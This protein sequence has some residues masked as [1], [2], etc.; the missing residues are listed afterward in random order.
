M[1][2]L[3]D[4]VKL[5]P[6]K[7]YDR[8]VFE[9]GPGRD[10]ELLTRPLEPLSE[11]ERRGWDQVSDVDLEILRHKF[12]SIVEEARDVY[13]NLSISEGII[14][15]DMNASIFTAQG[16]P[17]V[18][19][20]G[21]YFHALL[22]YAQVKYIL[23]YYR[24]DPTVGLKDGDIYFF[25][26][27][28]GG[29]V[30]T[31]DMFVTMPVFYKGQLIAW[32]EVGGHQG[33]T[34]SISPGGFSPKAKTRWEEGLHAHALRIGENDEIR[35]DILDF[36]CNS[37]RNP[38]VFASDL[39]AR[40]ATCVRIRERLLRE[41]ERR[42][43]EVVAA[44][45]RKILHVTAQQAR[46]RLRQL[47]DG[48][49]RNI[50]F[51]DTVGGDEGLL[52]IPT[53]VIKEDDRMTV[54]VQGVS[55]EHGMGPIHGTWHLTRAALGVYLFSYMF[56]GLPPNA[57]LLDP[58]EVL[59]EGPSFANST[60]E[61]AHGEGTLP[62][63]CV[64]QN[65]HVIGSKMLFDSP[66]REAVCAPHSR[67]VLVYIYAGQNRYGYTAANFT[68]TANAGGQGA[69]FDLDGEHALGFFW[70]PFTD[71]GEVEDTDS[72]LP[73]LVL[74][75]TIGKNYHGFG[76]FRGGS[77]LIEIAAAWG[78]R[79]CLMT[80]WGCCDKVSHN[81]GIFGGYW[82][83]PNPR[84]VITKTNLKQLLAEK[85]DVDLADM[86]EIL[87]KQ[88]IQGNYRF[89]PSSG[90][91][92]R[93]EEGDVFIWNIGAGGGYGDVLERDPELVMEDVRAGYITPDIAERIYKV[94]FDP[95]T[96]R[97]DHEATHR[98]RQA[99]REDR[100]RRGKPFHEFIDQ[101]LRQRPKPEILKYYGHWPEPNLEHYDKPFWGLY[102]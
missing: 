30:H 26:D 13:M 66:Y 59:V 50:L 77:P 62:A 76:K 71:S 27:E 4:Q 53:T 7:I 52:R 102:E 55:P 20:T 3:R 34:G 10:P 21:I 17:A 48:I 86:L 40:V 29:G 57:G 41:V 74:A 8:D 92:E 9:K 1:G 95:E 60:A 28:L 37:V 18:V 98:L 88:P 78:P 91:T 79:G 68:G 19:A 73:P 65:M 56:R 31:F 93:F 89:E 49:Y 2:R 25:N 96:L 70:G 69:R 24:D 87:T 22:N 36:L 81:P 38:F 6:G 51:V 75:R 45:L 15:G 23:K 35:R 58:V 101:W 94:A 82:G 85:T 90:A 84:V 14:T 47:N 61:V 32:A 44:A 72:R 46:Q 99:E 67:N 64:V 5:L 39:R 100:K 43:V 11:L 80:S 54:L 83:P 97:V 42:G 12:T 16:D 63:A 33:E